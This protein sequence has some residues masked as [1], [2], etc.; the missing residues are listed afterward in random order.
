VEWIVYYNGERL[1]SAVMFLPP[2]DIFKGRAA[3][4]LAERRIKLYDAYIS[5]Q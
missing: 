4:W 1:R 2:D 5:G 3:E